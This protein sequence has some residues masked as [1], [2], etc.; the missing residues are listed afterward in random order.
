MSDRESVRKL[1]ILRHAA[2]GIGTR[3][4]KLRV[5]KLMKAAPLAR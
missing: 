5:N 2:C 3:T 4:L 1:K